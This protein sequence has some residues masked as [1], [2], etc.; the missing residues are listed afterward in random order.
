MCSL[1]ASGP[2]SA[3]IV[4]VSILVVA[5]LVILGLMA[6]AWRRH[7]A[8]DS[9][10]GVVT[11]DGGDALEATV[12]PLYATYV[13]TTHAHRPLERIHSHTL[14]ERSKARVWLT[15]THV[16]LEREGATSFTIPLSGLAARE[17]SGQAGKYTGGHGILTL[18]WTLGE[19]P[20]DTGLRL[21]RREDHTT[22]LHALNSLPKETP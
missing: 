7:V 1:S 21:A 4:P 17:T 3:A 5:F 12:G 10:L 2:G 8:R 11:W 19:T 16:A 14:G 9:N 22:L 18:T 6:L 15:N 13:S 20:V